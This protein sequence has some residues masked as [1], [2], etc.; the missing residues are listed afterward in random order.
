[1][2][3][4]FQP[5]T[6]SIVSHWLSVSESLLLLRF[7]IGGTP[8]QDDPCWCDC[9]F[10]F[11]TACAATFHL[12]GFLVLQCRCLFFPK[13]IHESNDCL[14]NFPAAW[15]AT[16]HVQGFLQR[17]RCLFFPKSIHDSKLSI[18]PINASSEFNIIL[19][20]ESYIM[21]YVCSW[22]INY[23][24][25]VQQSKCNSL[26]PVHCYADERLPPATV[27]LNKLRHICHLMPNRLA[28]LLHPQRIYG[29]SIIWYW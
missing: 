6:C 9:L 4:Y 1:M 24:Q 17:C 28:Q 25:P 19:I 10:N 2:Y 21:I 15:A 22:Q 5:L 3:S 20:N 13:S 23:W 27:L 29:L 8:I 18:N 26:L 12:Q 14:F 7:S 11:P 16:F